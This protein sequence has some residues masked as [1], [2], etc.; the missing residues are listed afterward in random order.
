MKKYISALSAG[1]LSM[2]IFL[3]TAANAAAE[4]IDYV[5]FG[6]SIAAGQTPYNVRVGTSYTDFI[7]AEL[8]EE[9]MLSS[10][11]KE[12]AVS[13]ETSA[14]FLAK[15]SLPNVKEAVEKAEL[16]TIS[17]GA[18]DLLKLA[19]AGNTDPIK[20]LEAVAQVDRNVTAGIEQIKA[21][22]PAVDVYVTGYYFP[23]PHMEEGKQKDNLKDLFTLF[24]TQLKTTAE[25]Q[26][27]VFVDASHKFGVDYL[28]NPSDIHPNTA[29]YQLIADQFFAVWKGVSDSPAKDPF[30]DISTTGS[31][32]RL[33]I[34]KLAENGIISGNA[35]GT[36]APKNDITRAEA[37]IILARILGQTEAA[38]NPGFSDVSPQMK[39]YSA[40]AQLTKA[41]VFAKAP[42]FKPNEPLTRA[43]LARILTQALNL[44]ADTAAAFTDVPAAHW[45]KNEID[46]VYAKGLM[47]GGTNAKFLPEASITREQFAMT[48]FNVWSSKQP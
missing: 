23:F 7:A 3:V 16:I 26:G 2:G 12:F 31:K 18:N 44:K 39:S 9:G 5:A 27:A 24:N 6:D 43:Q 32:A 37:A 4:K 38:P 20:L 17:T 13:G 42:K 11:T 28:P 29:G 41:G 47:T 25:K 1:V 48:L 30:S 40:I 14:Q 35:D 8:N 36:F 45:A 22:N 33:A 19:L 15:L 34:M 10:F 21:L 46:A